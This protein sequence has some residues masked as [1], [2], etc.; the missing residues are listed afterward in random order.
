MRYVVFTGGG[1]G[2]HIVPGLAVAEVFNSDAEYKILWIGAAKGVDRDIVSPSGLEFIGIPAGKLRRYFSFRNFTDLFKIAG[3][4]IKSFFI[5]RKL[6]PE[7]VFSKGGFVSV[8]PCAAARLLKIPV[9]T[10]ECDFSPGLATRLNA[11]FAEKILVSYPKTADFFKPALRSKILCTGNPIRLGFYD[12]S[13]EKGRQFLNAGTEKPVLLVLGG[14]LGAEQING[15]VFSL[16]EFLTAHFCVVHQTGAQHAEKAEKIKN[17]LL[18]SDSCRAENYKPYGFIKSEM[19]E[20]LA[21]AA[22][23]LSRAGANTVWEA[24][25]A[26]KPMILIPLEKASSRGD[27]IENAEF[28][29]E[30]GAAE[31]LCGENAAAEK[32]QAVL[33]EF[34]ENPEKLKKTA[35]AA[36]ALASD[37][38]AVTI[39]RFLKEFL[40]SRKS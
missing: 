31:V 24:A 5:L 37:K 23:V 2:G 14:S 10:H 13:A 26:G 15:L 7:L 16:I 33:T 11:E 9:I 30:R 8:P 40:H 25:A 6:K 27:Q 34:L 28:F 35:Q 17:G 39:A 32:V 19:P 12:A 22:L 20:V 21:A 29:K 18:K 38:P 36:E 3:G 4:F 1:T